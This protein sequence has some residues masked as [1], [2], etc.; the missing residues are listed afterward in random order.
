M[1]FVDILKDQVDITTIIMLLYT[2]ALITA[3]CMFYSMLKN[4]RNKLYDSFQLLNK[5]FNENKI[6]DSYDIQY[7]Y[8]DYSRYNLN[9]SYTT[10]L[11]RYIVF[12]Q[13]NDLDVEQFNLKKNLIKE[14]LEEE[15]K[16]RPFDGVNE[17]EKRLLISISDSAKNNELL[18]VEHELGELS[19]ILKNNQK[20]MNIAATMNRWTVPISIISIVLTV[21]IWIFGRTSISEEDIRTIN[22]NTKMSIE[23]VIRLNK[24]TKL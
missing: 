15:K 14:I 13:K 5:C 21:V 11:E 3:I 7:I 23:K 8:N 4:R 18:S 24:Q 10:F 17:H 2:I 16:E 19:L 1:S 6:E 12:L 9:M 22:N 20:R